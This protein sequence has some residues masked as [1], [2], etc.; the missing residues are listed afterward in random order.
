MWRMIYSAALNLHRLPKLVETMH[1]MSDQQENYTDRERYDYVRYIVGLM[2]R[3][4]HIRTDGYG[5]E[6]LPA[7]GGYVMYANHQG[8]YD[9]YSVVAVHAEP[10]TVVMD[11]EKSYYIFV[12]EIIDTLRGK[13]L[14]LHD[15]R[16]NLKIINQVAGEVAQGRRY[17]IFPAGGYAKDQRNRVGDF[18]AGSFKAA[19]KAKAP[20]VP[21]ALYDSYKAYNSAQLTPVKTQVHFLDPIPY[22]TYKDL[23]TYQISDMVK[24]RIEGKIAEIKSGKTITA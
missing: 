16:Q 12:S 7:E 15:V 14:D 6:K 13:R 22:D 19:V 3:S 1:R 17:L 11:R 5:M 10:C 2:K 18:K 9:A 4:G 24:A 20:I 23:N 21:V 8:K